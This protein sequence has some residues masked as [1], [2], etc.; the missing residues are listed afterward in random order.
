ML[1]ELYKYHQDWLNI[2]YTFLQSKEDAE[3]MVQEMYI[4]VDK[5]DIELD[6]V[7]Y[8]NGLNKYFFYQMLR[9][10][11]LLHLKDREKRM[12]TDTAYFETDHE[13]SQDAEA[14][15]ELFN[16]IDEYVS[17]WNPYERELFKIYMYSGLSF[18]DISHGTIANQGIKDE[19]KQPKLI[20]ASEKIQKE[21]AERG[22]TISVMSIYT[23]I[24]KCK[25]RLK[26]RFSEDFEDW[27]NNNYDKI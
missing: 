19:P 9:N 25:E 6:N 8:K 16:R 4:R 5:Y 10:M 24:K 14:L 15:Q 27:H 7:R 20:S 22:T 2:A 12:L 17:T 23:T 26:K 3:D 11:C 13:H 21:S 1:E 18:R